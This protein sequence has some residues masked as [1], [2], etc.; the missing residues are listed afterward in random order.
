[1]RK[2]LH[3]YGALEKGHVDYHPKC[4]RQFYGTSEAPVLSYEQAALRSLAAQAAKRSI[5]VPG[6]QPKLSLDWLESD[7]SNR[8]TILD[9][10]DG[11]FIL[12]P[13]NEKYAQ[14]PENEHLTMKLAQEFG[15]QVVPFNM[16]RLKSGE[17]CYIT[18]RIDRNKDG[19]KRHMIDFLQILELEDKYKGTLE[20]LGKKIGELS[21]N[22]LFDKLRFFESTVFS[23]VIG[24]NDMHLKNYSMW[25]SDAGWVLSSFYDLL[26]TKIILPKDKDDLAL[27]LGG[28]RHGFKKT[29]FDQLG[30]NL[31]LNAK[32]IKG[33]YKRLEKWQEVAQV[34]IRSSFLSKDYKTQY[35]A[36]IQKRAALILRDE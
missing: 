8:L 32:Q 11:K 19:S 28:K 31:G 35:S 1:M 33:V 23:F 10:L 6:A 25:L 2:C 27:M 14:M 24:N 13:Q 7:H 34:V 29:N 36:L 12:K 5:A 3:C 22:T 9:A 16:V 4:I 18:K 20:R 17:L 26:N 21:V 30:A 15:L